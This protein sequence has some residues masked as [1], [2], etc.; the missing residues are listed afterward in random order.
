MFHTNWRFVESQDCLTN[1]RIMNPPTNLNISRLHTHTCTAHLACTNV[2]MHIA[3]LKSLVVYS[4]V[5]NLMC[6]FWDLESR[7]FRV[8]GNCFD[9]N[10]KECFKHKEDVAKMIISVAMV[11]QFKL[12]TCSSKWLVV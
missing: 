10:C 5:S 3:T 4:F 8:H 12:L 6:D 11:M 1:L 2:M 9:L 7:Q